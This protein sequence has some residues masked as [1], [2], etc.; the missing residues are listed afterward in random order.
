MQLANLKN[1]S[2]LSKPNHVEAY[3]AIRKENE[4]LAQ[5]E[6][7]QEKIATKLKIISPRVLGK[8]FNDFNVDYKPQARVKHIAETYTMTFGERLI[9]G[10][11]IVFHGHCGT[12]K[13]YLALII[14]QELINKG[15]NLC[16]EPSLQF[17]RF[18]HEK[19]F[20]SSANFKNALDKYLSVDLFI[21]DE[22]TEGSCRDGS[23]S[24]SE[25]Q[26]LFAIIDARYY[27]QKPNLII[28]NLT[29]EK[30]INRL[31]QPIADRISHKGINL[32]FTWDSYRK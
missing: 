10:C 11:S 29:K 18:L 7:R 28:T 8:T 3:E 24:P 12:G 22:A 19:N 30:I 5:E 14:Y 13:T 4:R 9:E 32:A 27:A 6:Y 1:R 31:G 2:G 20:E 26:M 25:K 23:L 21:I 17:L 16:Y 15:F